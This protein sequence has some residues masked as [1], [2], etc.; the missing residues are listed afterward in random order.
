MIWANVTKFGQN[1]IAPQNFL[2]WYGYERYYCKTVLV[3]APICP[4][5]PPIFQFLASV[6]FIIPNDPRG[7]RAIFG[8]LFSKYNVLNTVQRIKKK[9]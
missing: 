3:T 4:Q 8:N 2:G 6:H 9:K 7:A 1:F 5:R